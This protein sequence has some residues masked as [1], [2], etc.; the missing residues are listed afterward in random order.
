MYYLCGWYL[1]F[2]CQLIEK[3]GSGSLLYDA[4]QEKHRKPMI[5][6]VFADPAPLLYKV[7][8]HQDADGHNVAFWGADQHQKVMEKC[9]DEMESKSADWN[10]VSIHSDNGSDVLKAAKNVKKKRKDQN[11]GDVDILRDSS[12]TLDL[13]TGQ[14]ILIIITIF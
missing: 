12:H 10:I 13:I 2:M 9:I 3:A 4:S 7:E 8:G 14:Y 5:H 11:K 1:L 6:S